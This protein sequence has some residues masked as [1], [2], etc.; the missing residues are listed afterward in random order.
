MRNAVANGLREHG[1]DILTAHDAGRCGFSD[2][3]QIRFAT[4]EGRAV[5]THDIDYVVWSADFQRRGEGFA[6]IVYCDPAKY[7]YHPGRLMTDLL[8][9]HG[10]FTADDLRDRLEYL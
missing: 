7:L 10:V 8:I 6:G 4:T 9:L 1:A 3:E 5:V 2:E